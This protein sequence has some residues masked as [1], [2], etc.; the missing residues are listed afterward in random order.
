MAVHRTACPF[1]SLS[2]AYNIIAVIFDQRSPASI[3]RCSRVTG[4][5]QLTTWRNSSA[6]RLRGEST[7]EYSVTIHGLEVESHS[8]S[9]K[10]RGASLSAFVSSQHSIFN[11]QL[12]V[13]SLIL[14]T[15]IFLF[16][17]NRVQ[18]VNKPS[19]TPPNIANFIV[20]V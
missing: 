17:S 7:V 6:T 19:D 4:R 18:C 15:L 16:D 1:H 8:L 5:N 20:L 3:S 11:C 9:S 12:R 10:W 2:T 14:I 13:R